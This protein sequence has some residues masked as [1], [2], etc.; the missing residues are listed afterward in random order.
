MIEFV[1]ENITWIKES[2]GVLVSVLTLVIA[3]FT[4]RRARHTIFQ[5][6]RTE[7]IKHQMLL[8]EKIADSLYPQAIS[9]NFDFV[10][11][12][13]ATLYVYLRKIGCSYGEEIDKA[14][15]DSIGG[16][17][18]N[19]FIHILDPFFFRDVDLLTGPFVSL[20]LSTDE[21]SKSLKPNKKG[22][23]PVK[24]VY[25]TKK[26]LNAINEVRQIWNN[27]W[28]PKRVKDEI[29][30]AASCVEQRINVV[31]RDFV[32]EEI[33]K[34]YKA[35]KKGENAPRK[36]EEDIKKFEKIIK[37]SETYTTYNTDRLQSTIQKH[38]RVNNKW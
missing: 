17:V 33:A 19:L 5:P 16:V 7:V 31:V 32:D 18:E 28:L 30:G 23:G 9:E 34:Y 37:S 10:G 12:A 8:F 1:K 24:E 22:V 20:S 2:I 3:F 25:L 15:E 35:L 38:L 6:L 11:N 14:I 26:C 21:E 4:Y 13:V 36:I 27:P 29:Y